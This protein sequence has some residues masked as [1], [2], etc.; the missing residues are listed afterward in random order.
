MGTGEVAPQVTITSPADGATVAGTIEVNGH[1]IDDQGDLPTDADGHPVRRRR[2]P[3]DE[4]TAGRATAPSS[5]A[6]RHARACL[7]ELTT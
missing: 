5:F 3:L 7:T 6:A 1:V 4:P 2:L